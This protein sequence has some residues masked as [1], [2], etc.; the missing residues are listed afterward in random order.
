MTGEGERLV[1]FR[2][3]DEAGNVEEV[4]SRTVK[5]DT[6]VPTVDAAVAGTD[7]RC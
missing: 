3:T 4:G 5:I 6:V 7:T 2:S 1:E